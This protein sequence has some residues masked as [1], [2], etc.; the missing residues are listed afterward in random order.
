MKKLVSSLVILGFVST[1]AFAG[2]DY[3]SAPS[4]VCTY[5]QDCKAC[6]VGNWLWDGTKFILKLPFR[7][8]TSTGKGVYDLVVDQDFSGFQEGYE[9]I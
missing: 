4:E 6:D 8:V 3:R 9:I 1:P 5:K 7:I 2:G